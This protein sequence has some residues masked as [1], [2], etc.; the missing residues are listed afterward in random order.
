M[1][2][3]ERRRYYLNL[4]LSN[5]KDEKIFIQNQ[6][7]ISSVNNEESPYGSFS[8]FVKLNP[9]EIAYYLD[10]T[11]NNNLYYGHNYYLYEETLGSYY[12]G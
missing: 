3:S 5:H 2:C 8:E 10:L 9:Y 6:T 7:T 11:L 4:K 1:K 12:R